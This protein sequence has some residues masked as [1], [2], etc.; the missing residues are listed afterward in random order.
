MRIFPRAVLGASLCLVAF[1]P[2]EACDIACSESMGSGS[3]YA[4]SG[5]SGSTSHQD[6]RGSIDQYSGQDTSA[7]GAFLD[8]QNV[9][10]EPEA[11]TQPS[12]SPE[13]V[14]V[15]F[16]HNGQ[17]FNET[18]PRWLEERAQRARDQV[19]ESRRNRI[20]NI[21]PNEP[22]DEEVQLGDMFQSIFITMLLAS[23]NAES[24]ARD[25]YHEEIV[26]GLGLDR[27]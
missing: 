17:F 13:M 5:G 15:S 7:M 21:W 6:D 2:V 16:Y 24:T 1:A 11:P 25:S 14:R 22:I 20:S 8:A 3:P 27:V 9:D 4:A 23:Y 19:L 18:I 10:R 26:R 12:N